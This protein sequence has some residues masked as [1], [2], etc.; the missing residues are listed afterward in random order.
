M[1]LADTFGTENVCKRKLTNA[2]DRYVHKYKCKSRQIQNLIEDDT[3]RGVIPNSQTYTPHSDDCRLSLMHMSWTFENFKFQIFNPQAK[4]SHILMTAGRHSWT[5]LEDLRLQMT[6]FNKYKL[7]ILSA[8]LV[9]ILTS[10]FSLTIFH[11]RMFGFM[12]RESRVEWIR[13]QR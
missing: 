13:A 6:N 2:I 9:V 8:R 5:F 11:Q 10:T 4:R 7:Q 3:G 12:Y 1:Q